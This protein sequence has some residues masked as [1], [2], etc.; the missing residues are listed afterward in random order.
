MHPII[1]GE[2]DTWASVR[3][4]LG[5]ELPTTDLGDETT[6]TCTALAEIA[7][8]HISPTGARTHHQTRIGPRDTL[9]VHRLGLAHARQSARCS[10]AIP[11][12]DQCGDDGDGVANAHLHTA[13]LLARV[14]TLDSCPPQ[15]M[16]WLASLLPIRNDQCGKIQ[17]PPVLCKDMHARW[18]D[19]IARCN[20]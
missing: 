11:H 7:D 3:A 5:Y 20:N 16:D 17:Q 19:G 1:Q 6:L 9:A 8:R 10:T 4:D 12:I 2:L 14:L 15:D 18:P 13:V